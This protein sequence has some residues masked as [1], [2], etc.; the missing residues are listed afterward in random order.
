MIFKIFKLVI[1]NE[2]IWTLKHVLTVFF[3]QQYRL[4]FWLTVGR[5]TCAFLTCSFLLCRK[6]NKINDAVYNKIQTLLTAL[7]E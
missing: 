6:L 4:T 1:F 3:L 2:V 5:T 7:T